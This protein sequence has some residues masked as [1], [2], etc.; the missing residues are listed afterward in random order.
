MCRLRIRVSVSV[1]LLA[2]VYV[3][4]DFQEDKLFDWM[5]HQRMIIKIEG[6]E[7]MKLEVFFF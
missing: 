6:T 1:L 4:G 7:N 3:A 2:S 5:K